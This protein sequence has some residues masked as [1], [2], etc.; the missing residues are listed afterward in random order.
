MGDKLTGPRVKIYLISELWKKYWLIAL[1]TLLR[2]VCLK[3]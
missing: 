1:K 2:L 3:R